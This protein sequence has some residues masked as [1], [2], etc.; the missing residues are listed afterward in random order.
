M[1][2]KTNLHP[3]KTIVAEAVVKLLEYREAHPKA[4]E[5]DEWIGMSGEWD[6]NIY[7]H[8]GRIKSTLYPVFDGRTKTQEGYS[9]DVF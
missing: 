8:N 6:L 7:D 5:V 1:T 2:K 3:P 9:L 4:I